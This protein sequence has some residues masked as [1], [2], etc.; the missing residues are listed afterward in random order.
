MSMCSMDPLA[1]QRRAHADASE[2]DGACRS[3]KLCTALQIMPG[4]ALMIQRVM[5]A[6][7]RLAVVVFYLGAI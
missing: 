2:A 5:A 4:A 3:L 1:E 7:N 6:R